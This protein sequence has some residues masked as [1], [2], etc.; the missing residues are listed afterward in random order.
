VTGV[1][2]R[3]AIAAALVSLHDATLLDLEIDWARARVVI[4]VKRMERRLRFTLERVS[5]VECPREEPWGSSVSINA[6][7]ATADGVEIE[8]QSGDVIRIVGVVQ[9][10]VSTSYA[11]A[12]TTASADEA[13]S[14]WADH[15]GTRRSI[16]LP[17]SFEITGIRRK[18]L[19]PKM[20]V[21]ELRLLVEPASQLETRIA[22]DGIV[23]PSEQ[24]DFLDWGLLGFLDVVLTVEMSPLRE[25]RATVT[26]AVFDPIHSSLMA[27]RHAGRDAGRNLLAALSAGRP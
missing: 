10:L 18:A 6:A 11:G 7:C 4:Q 22:L 1:V 2:D 25:M 20:D 16:R 5:R 21:A 13:I 23:T 24:R 8:M 3:D 15:L 26:S 9:D 19:G 14:L 27:F 17:R 12:T